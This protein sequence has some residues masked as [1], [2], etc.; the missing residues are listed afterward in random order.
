MDLLLREA[1]LVIDS[2]RIKVEELEIDNEHVKNRGSSVN[3]DNSTFLENAKRLREL[4]IE[5][6][7]LLKK[8]LEMKVK[9]LEADKNKRMKS[10]RN[11]LLDRVEES[12]NYTNPSKS[13]SD[14]Q[15]ERLR[16]R[17]DMRRKKREEFAVTHR[18]KQ[19]EANLKMN[20]D[21]EEEN[22][23]SAR[24]ILE[25]SIVRK[26]DFGIMHV[27]LVE[28]SDGSF[29][30]PCIEDQTPPAFIKALIGNIGEDLIIEGRDVI[31]SSSVGYDTL[32]MF[33]SSCTS[34]TS[35]LECK[36]K[37]VLKNSLNNNKDELCWTL[38][39]EIGHFVSHN[40]RHLNKE[41]HLGKMLEEG[42]AEIFAMF[43][44]PLHPKAQVILKRSKEL[45]D[46]ESY[47]ELLKN[48]WNTNEQIFHESYELLPAYMYRYMET[49]GL[50]TLDE[51]LTQLYAHRRI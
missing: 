37:I 24:R 38:A 7:E 9:I 51:L 32:G 49:S 39:H 47:L 11:K 33:V 12:K 20:K 14:I 25:E 40:R 35:A 28:L 8:D 27:P 1:V 36:P 13:A 6:L 34:K 4:R 18:R 19:L 17:D 5:K 21:V 22:E 46:S 2:L 45:D 50:K 42:F 10:G 3:L 44:L 41:P 31:N 23:N 16:E 29:P 48:K 43:A 30:Y 15:N 26:R